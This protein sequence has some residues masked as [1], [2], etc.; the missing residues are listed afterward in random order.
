MDPNFKIKP[1]HVSVQAHSLIDV[2]YASLEQTNPDKHERNL[3]YLYTARDLFDLYRAL[4]STTGTVSKMLLYN[5]CVFLAHHIFTLGMQ[6]KDSIPSNCESSFSFLDIAPLLY[7]V[8]R[9]SLAK[10]LVF[11]F[12]LVLSKVTFK[13]HFDP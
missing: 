3:E 9:E 4:I 12:N 7:T 13:I 5:D 10:D 6:F 2:I 1:F 11:L 8:G